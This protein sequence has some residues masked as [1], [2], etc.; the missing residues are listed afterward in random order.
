MT[1]TVWSKVSRYFTSEPESAIVVNHWPSDSASG[2]GR[3]CPTSAASSTIVAGRSP[4]S[5]WSCSSTFGA[6]RACSWVTAGPALGSVRTA[7]MA[8][9]LSASP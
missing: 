1:A 4:P 7:L 8:A 2:A 9:I 5:R 6:R 3:V